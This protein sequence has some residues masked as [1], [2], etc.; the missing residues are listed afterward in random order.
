MRSLL[1][2]LWLATSTASAADWSMQPG[3]TLGFTCSFQGEAFTGRFGRFSPL[4][5]F[6]PAHLGQ[7]RFD[8]RIDLTS[9]DTRNEERDGML[10]GAEF[11]NTGTQAQARFVASRFRALGGRRYAADGVL[12]LNGLS[13]P[14]ALAFTWTAGTRPVLTGEA[15]LKRLDFAVGRGEWTDTGLLPNEV[16]VNTK[17]LL[18]PRK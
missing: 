18:A 16:K 1:L 11:F 8:V 13:K 14:V 17:L 15:S 7:S 2:L 6:D 3:S 5:R 9:A 10:R 12:T 4:I